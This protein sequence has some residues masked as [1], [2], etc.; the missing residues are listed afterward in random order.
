MRTVV[1]Q[2]NQLEA[3]LSSMVEGVVAFDREERIISV[4][5]AAAS[6]FEID[7]EKVRG[8]SIQE[9]IRNLAVQQFVSKALSSRAPIAEDIVVYQNGERV[10]NIRSAPL[11]GVGSE[12]IGTLMVFDDVTQVRRLETMRRDFVANVSHEIKTPLT[13]IKGFVETLHQGV[14]KD[15]EETERFLGIIAK[16]VER[17]STIVEDLL[18]LSRVEQEGEHNELKREPTRIWRRVPER[19]PDLP[20]E[21]R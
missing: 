15:P 11:S 3:V 1:S 7:P 17:L 16:H 6:W 13:A 8:R 19:D 9:T 10:L 21:S 20:A 14:V 4:N 5:P 2:R 18:V 12:P